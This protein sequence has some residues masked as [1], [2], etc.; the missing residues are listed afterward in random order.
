M[1]PNLSTS[2]GDW[3]DRPTVE[4]LPLLLAISR[5]GDADEA[6]DLLEV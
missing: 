2:A 3:G 4:L 1:K 5:G 6:E